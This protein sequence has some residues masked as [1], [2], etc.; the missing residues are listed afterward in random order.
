LDAF[1]DRPRWQSLNLVERTR[2][3]RANDDANGGARD[4][5]RARAGAS[6]ED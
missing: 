3:A 5:E 4:D 1:Y 2:R 6:S